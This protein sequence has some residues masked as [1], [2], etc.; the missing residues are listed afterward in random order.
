MIERIHSWD[1]TN[2]NW[3]V[4]TQATKPPQQNIPSNY[5]FGYRDEPYLHPFGGRWSLFTEY[6]PSTMIDTWA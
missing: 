2:Y 5:I 6:K 1:L 4:N 3:P